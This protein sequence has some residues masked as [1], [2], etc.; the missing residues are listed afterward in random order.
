MLQRRCRDREVRVAGQVRQPE[1]LAHVPRRLLEQVLGLL[2]VE[3]VLVDVV[4]DLHSGRDRVVDRGQPAEDLGDHLW[5]IDR[6]GDRLP[7]GLVGVLVVEVHREDADARHVELL[8][9]RNV[10]EAGAFRRRDP[11]HEVELAGRQ[12]GNRDVALLDLVH[13]CLD[14]A[15]LGSPIVG[16]RGERRTGRG[17]GRGE[18]VGAGAR[19]FARDA[20]AEIAILGLRRGEVLEDVL[21]LDVVHGA[22]D[23]PQE[24]AVRLAEGDLDGVIVDLFQALR[25]V[26]GP[27][28]GGSALDIE[29]LLDAELLERR[30]ILIG[31]RD[32]EDHIVRCDRLA[33]VPLRVHET[34]VPIAQIR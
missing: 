17:D 28:D 20:E 11:D 5:T 33:V 6:V 15:V 7:Q 21:R 27:L 12:L 32:R 4:V 29:P 19:S 34:T 1:G 14:L 24:R 18:V 23:P 30:G 22:G 3:V 10:G 26:L 9:A 16:L 2:Q 8:Q 13:D 31:P 25:D